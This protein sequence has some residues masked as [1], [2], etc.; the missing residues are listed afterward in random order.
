MK[1]IITADWH[2]G[3]P[4]RLDDLKTTF[5][6]MLD[7]C[8]SKEIKHIFILGDLTHD[9]EHMTHDV[10]NT[11]SELLI[12]AEERRI[13]IVAFVG[14]HDMFM[15]HKWS[16]NA[17]KPFSKHVTFVD[18]ISWFEFGGRKFWMV[19]F[20]EHEPT[21]MKIIKKLNEQVS[22]DDILLTHIG[23]A[24]AVMNA[25]FLVQNWSVVSFEETN[26]SRVYAGHFHNEQKVGSKSWY[27]GSPIPFRYDEGLVPHGFLEYDSES[28]EHEFIETYNIVKENRPADFITVESED[29]SSIL[30]DCSNDNVKVQLKEGDDKEEITK[31]LK[32]A[33]AAKITFVKPKEEALDFSNKPE[34]FRRSDNIFE[35]WVDY[36]K[37][38]NLDKDLLLCLEKEVRA[39]TQMDEDYD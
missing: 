17:L 34:N 32:N 39:D 20:I 26:F 10:S 13:N 25:C 12:E 15:R 9:R 27:P 30:G 1:A 19:P 7:Y 24:S 35:S 33:G 21:Y 38:E 16:P 2:F 6:G 37:P 4:G 23:I 3:Y 31:K 22:K 29:V 18:S 36:D 5:L 14:N 8:D 11:L 28:N